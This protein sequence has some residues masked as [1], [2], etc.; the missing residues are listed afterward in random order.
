MNLGLLKMT[1]I[2]N[3]RAISH[4]QLLGLH[5]PHRISLDETASQMASRQQTWFALCQNDL[6]TSL[7]L[8]LPYA[9][10]GKMIS[11]TVYGEP[12]T[13]EFFFYRVA[14][15]SARVIDR[16][17]MGYGTSTLETRDIERDIDAA[18]DQ[19]PREFWDAPAALNQG[20]IDREVY[21]ERLAC[22]FWFFQMKVLLHQP[23]M[24]QSIE[25][26]QLLHHRNACFSACRDTL[27]IYHLMRSDSLSTFGM[28]KLIDY[29]AFV[30]S[31]IL[32]LGLLGYGTSNPI[33]LSQTVDQY[34]DWE[35]VQSTLN[36]LRQASKDSSNSIASQAVQGLETLAMIV[37]SGKTGICLGSNYNPRNCL[38]KITIPGS[39][40]IS[41]VPGKLMKN[42]MSRSSKSSIVVPPPIFHLS[43][44]LSQDSPNQE[45][46]GLGSEQAAEMNTSSIPETDFNIPTMDFDWTNMID[47]DVGNDWAWLADVNDGVL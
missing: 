34:H 7:L 41:I 6:Y 31:A 18:A 5:R 9:T 20:R 30:C 40:V 11:S 46:S 36:V 22:Q 44:V 2:L 21:A 16:N 27:K 1:W 3:H 28:V 35:T 37:D 23:L 25:D 15:L 12:G 24:I 33:P 39:G 42:A 29:Q 26:H 45:F 13:L 17:Q 14:R 47:L 19:L 4:A 32:L 8:G 38:V 43:H 10:D